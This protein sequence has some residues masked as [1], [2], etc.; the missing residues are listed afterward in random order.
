MFLFSLMLGLPAAPQGPDRDERWV[1]APKSSCTIG[2]RKPGCVLYARRPA[3]AVTCGLDAGGVLAGGAHAGRTP[4]APG[5]RRDERWCAG[6]RADAKGVTSHLS[7][8]VNSGLT[9]DGSS[10]MNMESRVHVLAATLTVPK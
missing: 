9:C 3:G 7:M 4:P 2:G 5:A 1:A 8:D 6:S 10:T